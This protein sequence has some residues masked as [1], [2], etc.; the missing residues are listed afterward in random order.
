[1]NEL[2]TVRIAKRLGLT[3][4]VIRQLRARGL[5]DRLRLKDEEIDERLDRAFLAWRPPEQC[6]PTHKNH[7]RS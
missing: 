7:K 2:D 3:E 4:P 5:L 1:M 6:C